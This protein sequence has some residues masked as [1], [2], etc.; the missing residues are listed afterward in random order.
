MMQGKALTGRV[1]RIAILIA[2]VGLAGCEQFTGDAATGTPTGAVAAQARTV[3]QDVE[4]PDVFSETAQGL[5][6][7]RP[8][9]GG[10]W[11]AHPD[12]NMPERAL[13]RNTE[14]GRTL[15]AA[16]F[17]RERD[18]PGP[19]FQVSSD[20]AVELGL[21]PGAPVK[22]EVVALRRET[23]EVAPENPVV[24]ALEAP[25]AVSATP[26]EDAP[27]SED[28]GVG[29]AEAAGVVEV[30]NP[31]PAVAAATAA[32]AATTAATASGARKVVEEIDISSVLSAP[33]TAADGPRVQVGIFRDERN[34]IIT[35]EALQDL[36]YDVIAQPLNMGGNPAWRVSVG[37]LASR[38]A[39]IEAMEAIKSIGFGDAFVTGT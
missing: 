7:G 8:S 25:V 18:M 30:P 13:I 1:S 10:T 6:D 38:E 29:T 4:R 32:T 35:V 20:A 2:T 23:V 19:A 27:S 5:W 37:P 24:E 31:A 34:A 9:L 15:T 21:L 36:G 33:T 28:G 22:L 14:N 39:A 16:L 11:I 3:E 17:R 26:L 12:V